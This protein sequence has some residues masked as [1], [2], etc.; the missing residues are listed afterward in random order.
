MWL[1]NTTTLELEEFTL[2]PKC[3][4]II[5]SHTWEEHETSFRAWR[6]RRD[7]ESQ[8]YL[9]VKKFVDL[10][11]GAGHK[12][13]VG[14]F[15]MADTCCINKESS[16][17]LS[18]AI[19]SMYKYYED[20]AECYVYLS[21]LPTL[22]E[23]NDDGDSH[24]Q[25]QMAFSRSRWFTRGW[26]LQELLAPSAIAF[27]DRGWDTWGSKDTLTVDIANAAGVPAEVLDKSLMI[28]SYPIACRMSWASRRKTTRPE[29]TAY[30][31]FGIF[32]IYMPLLYGEGNRAFIRLQE[33]I[34]KK[35]T[36]KSLFAWS[37]PESRSPY[38]SRKS[39]FYLLQRPGAVFPQSF[40]EGHWISSCMD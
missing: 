21:D 37:N 16:A 22:A 25:R 38:I 35:T 11:R 4:Y 12:Y 6:K 40:W 5:L 36:D 23:T 2:H 3:Q 15:W 32:H 31:L 14:N 1:I 39:T 26:T 30:C 19:N 9:K 28:Q 13:A 20:A 34:S 8:G 10:A 33:E 27:F 18:E 7:T 29:D 17:E 24:H